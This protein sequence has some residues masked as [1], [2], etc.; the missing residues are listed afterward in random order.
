MMFE[1]DSDFKDEKRSDADYPDDKKLRS[2]L[3]L[4]LL[5]VGKSILTTTK[6]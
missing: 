3:S 4:S 1:M 5:D 2:A 6:R